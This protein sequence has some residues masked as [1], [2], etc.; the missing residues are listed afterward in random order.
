MFAGQ[1][2]IPELGHHNSGDLHLPPR[3]RNPGQH[4]VDHA[5]MSEF[6]DHL[7]NDGVSSDWRLIGAIREA[8]PVG[9]RGS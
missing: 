1:L 2:S 9:F 3:R 5:V 6:D 8:M 7:I 4:I